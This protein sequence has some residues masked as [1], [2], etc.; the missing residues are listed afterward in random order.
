MTRRG[1][2]QL[3]LIRNMN[4]AIQGLTLSRLTVLV[5]YRRKSRL[6]RVKVALSKLKTLQLSVEKLISLLDVNLEFFLRFLNIID[7]N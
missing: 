1:D 6:V 4:L 7:Q 2:L 3:L 5:N